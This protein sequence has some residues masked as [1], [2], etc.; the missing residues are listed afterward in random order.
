[1]EVCLCVKS[2]KEYLRY[3]I[4]FYDAKEKCVFSFVLIR[5]ECCDIAITVHFFPVFV[6][7]ERGLRSK[8]TH[9]VA[10]LTF[11]LTKDCSFIYYGS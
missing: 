6:S 2:I 8:Y 7:I 11:M 1:M 3:D 9:S 10:H 4:L 5:N